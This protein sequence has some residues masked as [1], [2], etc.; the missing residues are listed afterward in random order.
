VGYNRRTLKIPRSASV[1]EWLGNELVD[2]A[3]EA[4]GTIGTELVATT[5]KK[6]KSHKHGCN[7]M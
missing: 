7:V 1:E 6:T 5:C 2:K 4:V 3:V